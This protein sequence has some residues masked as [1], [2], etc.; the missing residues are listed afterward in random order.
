M[1]WLIIGIL[2][3]IFFS[4]SGTLFCFVFLNESGSIGA[5]CATG[6]CVVIT[7]I[8]V[9][10]LCVKELWNIGYI[11]SVIAILG[12]ILLIILSTVK[13]P[14]YW[15]EDGISI[16]L[17]AA[18]GVQPVICGI[19]YF[20]SLYP[21]EI[22]DEKEKNVL[23]KIKNKLNSQIK[24]LNNIIR[25]L[26]EISDKERIADEV[27]MLLDVISDSTINSKYNQMKLENNR[28]VFN[29]VCELNRKYNLDLCL[30]NKTIFEISKQLKEKISNKELQL[31]EINQNVNTRN[32]LKELKQILTELK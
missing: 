9:C 28:E 27:V 25:K 14:Y 22:Y 12:I 21:M 29:N 20:I 1:G 30:E 10:Y 23:N 26:T 17:F 5:W 18:F 6:I 2:L 11:L 32:N 3:L 7:C 15:E 31:K 13:T 19:A 8:V 4:G 16:R 24:E